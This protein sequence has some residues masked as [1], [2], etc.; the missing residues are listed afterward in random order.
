LYKFHAARSPTFALQ[1]YPDSGY[2]ARPVS[3]GEIT[4][5]LQ[6]LTSGNLL[7]IRI[8]MEE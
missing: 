3:L 7:K 1:I 2:L 6:K 5:G 4:K 8:G